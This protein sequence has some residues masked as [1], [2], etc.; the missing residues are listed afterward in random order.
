M[1]EADLKNNPEI[2]LL[3]GL[4]GSGKSTWLKDFI[5][6]STKSWVICST[7]NILDDYALKNNVTY[8]QAFNEHIKE[9]EKRFKQ[10]L[11]SALAAKENI[12]V[13]RTNLSKKSR[14]RILA[15][16]PKNY[17]KIAKVFNVDRTELNKRLLDRE[18]NTGKSISQ[19]VVDN[20]S[21]I[22]QEPDSNKFNHIW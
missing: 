22:Y 21:A 3:V 13:D 11:L 5:K 18:F 12:I 19:S 2:I 14:N 1:N 15:N 16:V 17:I 10:E 4:P 6:K 20:L 9:A 8:S 7:D